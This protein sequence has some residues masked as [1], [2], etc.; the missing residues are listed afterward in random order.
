MGTKRK[1]AQKN[2]AFKKTKL[3]V[4]RHFSLHLK[5]TICAIFCCCSGWKDLEKDEHNWFDDR[6]KEGRPSD[7]IG[8]A[9][10]LEHCCLLLS[11]R[12]WP[13]SEE[14][15]RFIE[16]SYEKN[17]SLHKHKC[18]YLEVTLLQS[19]EVNYLFSQWPQSRQSLFAARAL[20]QGLSLNTRHYLFIGISK[21]LFCCWCC[22][23]YRYL[24]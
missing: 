19:S 2:A 23:C 7:P 11:V 22:C 5:N 17:N 3:K 24:E 15:D 8:G 13:F 4:S 18:I 14:F 9:K 21:S 20:Q 6:V 10:W 16:S 1:K 12:Y